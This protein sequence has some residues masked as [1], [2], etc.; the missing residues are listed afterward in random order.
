MQRKAKTMTTW[1]I[2]WF[3]VTRFLILTGVFASLFMGYAIT[4]L[5]NEIIL[6]MK[7]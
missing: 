2:I 3:T 7:G 4:D 6:M 5:M 1:E